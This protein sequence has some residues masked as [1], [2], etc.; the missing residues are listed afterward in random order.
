MNTTFD[1][2]EKRQYGVDIYDFI[3]DKDYRREFVDLGL[4]K[5]IRKRVAAGEPMPEDKVNHVVYEVTGSIDELSRIENTELL[6]KKI[7]AGPT[8]DPRIKN[9]G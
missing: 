2:D 9:N 4:P 7:A 3:T 6:D 1:R 8:E 5:L